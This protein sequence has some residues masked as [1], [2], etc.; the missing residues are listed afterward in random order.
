MSLQYST[1]IPMY[2]IYDF[3][4]DIL[5]IRLY[6]GDSMFCLLVHNNLLGENNSRCFMKN[7]WNYA[8]D[9]YFVN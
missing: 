2:T 4:I 5:Y 8:C 1:E 6:I 3:Y 9:R 7:I